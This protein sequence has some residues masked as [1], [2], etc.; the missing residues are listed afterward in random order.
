MSLPPFLDEQGLVISI[1][2]VSADGKSY[3]WR[4]MGIVRLRKKGNVLTKL[5]APTYSSI[6][7]Q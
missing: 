5:L 7:F 2:A 1:E 6:R 3:P 4:E